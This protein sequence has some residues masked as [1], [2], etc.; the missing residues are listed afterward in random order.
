MAREYTDYKTGCASMPLSLLQMLASCIVT[1]ASGNT[2]LNVIPTDG[3]CADYTPLISCLNGDKDPERM[4][5]ENIFALDSCGNL[6]IK[7]FETTAEQ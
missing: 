1:D 5:V 7:T 2:F 6:G 3:D 4:L